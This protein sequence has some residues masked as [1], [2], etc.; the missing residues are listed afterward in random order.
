MAMIVVPSCLLHGLFG[1]MQEN[2]LPQNIVVAI[3]D[4][5]NF[6][7][8]Y[9]FKEPEHC[10]FCKFSKSIIKTRMTLLIHFFVL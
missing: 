9:C 3:T 8:R 1:D 7:V 4:F 5:W 10:I 6:G 2:H